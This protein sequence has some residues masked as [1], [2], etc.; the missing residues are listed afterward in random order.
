MKRLIV[1]VDLDVYNSLAKLSHGVRTNT[2]R[3]LAKKVANISD[4]HNG[5]INSNRILELLNEED[6]FE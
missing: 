3:E 5:R 2:F 1:E 6:R 4:S